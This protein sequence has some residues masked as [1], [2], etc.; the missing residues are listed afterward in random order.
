MQLHIRLE[1]DVYRKF[2]DYV[3][4][5]GISRAEALNFLIKDGMSNDILK[6]YKKEEIDKNI[7]L[8]AALRVFA[9]PLKKIGRVTYIEFDQYLIYPVFKKMGVESSV[10]IVEEER[11]ARLVADAKKSKKT[12]IILLCLMAYGMNF[13]TGFEPLKLPISMPKE[14]NYTTYRSP[15]LGVYLRTRNS[16]EVEAIKKL[17][18]HSGLNIEDIRDIEKKIF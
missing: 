12:P 5:Y 10:V 11:V 4:N 6:N 18:E 1:D 14:E 7:F 15:S 13:V 3:D 2:T 9:A 8:N 16:E 17:R